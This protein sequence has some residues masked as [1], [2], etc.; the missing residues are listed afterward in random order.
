MKKNILALGK[1]LH[2]TDQKKIKGGSMAFSD[3]CDEDPGSLECICKKK[4]KPRL[5]LCD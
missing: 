3:A 4:T 5:V 1:V 2:H